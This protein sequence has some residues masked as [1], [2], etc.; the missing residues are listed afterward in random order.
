MSKR[1]NRDEIVSKR[2]QEIVKK[3]EDE[4][5]EELQKLRL[6]I[7][8]LAKEE[9]DALIES[10]ENL[11]VNYYYDVFCCQSYTCHFSAWGERGFDSVASDFKKCVTFM[12]WLREYYGLKLSA[13]YKH[14]EFADKWMTTEISQFLQSFVKTWNECHSE[15]VLFWEKEFPFRVGIKKN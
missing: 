7:P 9:E 15:Y 8:Q 10:V 12:S 2:I 4:D 3:K 5:Q 13:L 14:T 1:D 6:K 11:I